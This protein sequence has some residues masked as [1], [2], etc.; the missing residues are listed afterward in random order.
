MT[1]FLWLVW[2]LILQIFE[3][4]YFQTNIVHDY[5]KSYYVAN[6]W[7]EV[8][9]VKHQV[10]NYQPFEDNGSYDSSVWNITY[11]AEFSAKN[12]SGYICKT[13]KPQ[14]TY[15]QILYYFADD[16]S[17]IASINKPSANYTNI[18]SSNVSFDNVVWQ[19][20]FS[21][22]KYDPSTL[23]THDNLDGNSARDAENKSLSNSTTLIPNPN[24]VNK[25][26]I[27]NISESDASFCIK[28]DGVPSNLLNIK[29]IWTYKKSVVTLYAE[30][31]MN[32]L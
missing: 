28:S 2:I 30:K 25:I 8:E 26:S 24:Y 12:L 9:L 17:L 6:A 22:P 29:S 23:I 13:L 7:I 5:Y 16:K 14:E 32:D 3:G 19:L 1:I 18:I 21:M 27:S 15:W 10:R 11:K 20:D 31:T 4:I